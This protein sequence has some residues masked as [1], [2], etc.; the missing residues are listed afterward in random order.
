MSSVQL[1]RLPEKFNFS[2][3]KKFNEDIDAAL[4]EQD[5]QEVHLDFSTV[6][7]LDSAALGM[8]VYLHKKAAAVN[9]SV[10][11]INASGTAAEILQVANIAKIV[12]IK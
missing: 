9:K 2:H 5:V 7:Y 3:H 8:I 10:V 4:K 6:S 11:I 12:Q 1:V